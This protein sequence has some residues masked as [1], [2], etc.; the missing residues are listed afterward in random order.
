MTTVALVL[1][2]FF[3]TYYLA[4]LVQVMFHRLIGHA[5]R[6]ARLYDVHVRGHHAQWRSPP[7]FP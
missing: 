6:I 7:M 3:G 4:S 1:A 5:P 2:T